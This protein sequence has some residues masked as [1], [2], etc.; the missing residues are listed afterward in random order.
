MWDGWAPLAYLPLPHPPCT[1]P[2]PRLPLPPPAGR[3]PSLPS[4]EPLP[5]ACLQEAVAGSC[6]MPPEVAFTHG[7]ALGVQLAALQLLQVMVD[8]VGGR[9]T[10]VGVLAEHASLP[11]PAWGL[12]PPGSPALC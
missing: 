4:P 2:P 9:C 11:A 7:L 5:W 1:V 12:P 8:Q 3:P 10:P 6:V